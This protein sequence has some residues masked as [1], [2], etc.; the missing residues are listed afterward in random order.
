MTR[1]DITGLASRGD[2]VPWD[3]SCF[4]YCRA[5]VARD[6][7][8]PEDDRSADWRFYL[9]VDAV[10]AALVISPGLGTVVEGLASS[11]ERVY[12]ACADR[13][14]LRAVARRC[15]A[16]GLTNVACVQAREEQLPIHPG[17]LD[18]I[19]MGAPG[20]EAPAIGAL[21]AVAAG[22]LRAGGHA[23]AIVP[24]SLSFVRPRADARAASLG[25]CRRAFR[26]AGFAEAQV[27]AVLPSPDVPPHF[28][29]PLDEP[30]PFE[31]FLRNLAP[32]FDT[33]SPEVRRRYAIRLLIARAGLRVALG[34][35][36]PGLASHF[37]PAFGIVARKAG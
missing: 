9:P 2:T 8:L 37:V 33:V 30:G 36:L 23:C 31:Y 19:A 11:C 10:K 34:G 15:A 21:A 6:G 13:A 3:E 16:R 20:G 24:N 27:F 1:T 7:L 12:V 28:W 32:L 5:R 22:L 26:A 4:D 18:L 29:V 17:S 25:R 35:G 14:T